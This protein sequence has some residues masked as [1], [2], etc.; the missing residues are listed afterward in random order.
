M[1]AGRSVEVA[2]LVVRERTLDVRRHDL[3]GRKRLVPVDLNRAEG[4]EHTAR[5]VRLFEHAPPLVGV[6][7]CDSCANVLP[8]YDV[9]G[10]ETS[11]AWRSGSSQWRSV[12][13][14]RNRRPPRS[15]STPPVGN[16]APPATIRRP[17]MTGAKR[18]WK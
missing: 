8:A 10:S 13:Q 6:E 4:N 11:A 18:S 3:T 2:V 14:P 15:L 17:S 7:R 5:R 1:N 12:V 9:H 16:S